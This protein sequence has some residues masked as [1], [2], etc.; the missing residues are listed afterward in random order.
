MRRVFAANYPSAKLYAND[1]RNMH[2]A[3][4][5]EVDG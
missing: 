1:L 3:G 4:E 5:I 2:L